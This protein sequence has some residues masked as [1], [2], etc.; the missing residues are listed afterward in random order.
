M[1]RTVDYESK[2]PISRFGCA[3]THC[4]RSDKPLD[5]LDPRF[6]ICKMKR[7]SE[8]MSKDLVQLSESINFLLKIV[9]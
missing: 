6:L 4:K 7:E 5:S 2:D 1:E 9:Q 3:L 8:M